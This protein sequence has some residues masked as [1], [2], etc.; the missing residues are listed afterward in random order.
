MIAADFRPG[1]DATVEGIPRGW[2]SSD[3]SSPPG[4]IVVQSWQDERVKLDVDAVR[5]ALL[6][7]NDSFFPG[8]QATIDGAP[9]KIFKTNGLVRGVYVGRGHHRIAFEYAPKSFALGLRISPSATLVVLVGIAAI[10]A[11]R[12]PRV[13]RL[14]FGAA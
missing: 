6:V 3:D 11:L 4:T 9:T 12:R 1:V 8:W 14:R 5:P 10:V 7:L 13:V 2:Q